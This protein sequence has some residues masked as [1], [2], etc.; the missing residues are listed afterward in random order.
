MT[1][2]PSKITLF[3]LGGTIASQQGASGR[4]VTGAMN[5]AELICSLGLDTDV[6]L[7]VVTL[8]TKP[9][10]A[11][12]SND[13]FNLR[14]NCVQAVKNGATGIVVSQ[15]TDTLEDSAFLLDLITELPTAALVVTGAQRVP[16]VRGSD[17]GPNLRDAI[18]VAASPAAR[19]I[20]VVVVFDQEIHAANTVRK[21]S[22][23]RLRGFGSIEH[24][25]LGYVDENHVELRTASRFM[26][27]FP[28]LKPPL[29]RVDILPATM[30]ASP[31]LLKAAVDSGAQGLVLDGLGRGQVPPDWMPNIELLRSQGVPIAVV[32]STLSGRLG[33][34]YDCTGSL[35]E[36]ISLGI[37]PCHELTARKARLLLMCQI[38]TNA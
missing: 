11:L 10:N 13:I 15:G 21:I 35:A 36:L 22:S 27:S 3:A 29:P 6:S 14:D 23:H 33:E 32:S 26:H 28:D 34:D 5:G 24:G 2:H 18:T 19:G 1:T 16:Y 37:Q 25:P 17:A 12:T 30:E 7:D 4:A 9:S 31:L 8:A 38:A 20:G